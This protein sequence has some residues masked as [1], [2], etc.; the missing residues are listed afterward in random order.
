MFC[1]VFVLQNQPEGKLCT[2]IFL[3]LGFWPVVAAASERGGRSLQ[4]A[5]SPP[6]QSGSN[7][8]RFNRQQSLFSALDE[9]SGASGA[10]ACRL[11]TSRPRTASRANFAPGPTRNSDNMQDSRV[12]SD[13]GL[14]SARQ[15]G[16]S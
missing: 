2:S 4:P 9:A 12:M 13:S 6:L 16:H 11:G 8:F 3:E 15:T 1:T 5:Q 14:D 7:A 10:F